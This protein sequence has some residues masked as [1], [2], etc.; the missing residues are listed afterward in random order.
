MWAPIF[1]SLLFQGFGFP[2]FLIPF[3]L[4]VFAF[5]FIFRWEWKYL[6]LKWGGWFVILIATSSLVGLW[7]KPLLVYPKDLLAGGF[8]GEI[9]SR[10]LVRYFNRPG[11]TILLLLILMI[12]FVLGTGI[13]FISLVRRLGN[14]ASRIDEKIGTMRMVRKEQA[15]RAK[16][17]IKSEK[18]EEGKESKEVVPPVVVSKRPLLPKPKEAM[19]QESFEFMEDSKVFQLPPI[20]SAG[21]RCG[22]EA[23]D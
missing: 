17:L 2:S 5:S 10:N 23:E 15:K 11:A 20:T 22:E 13:S 12:A 9:F 16:K 3:L 18:D 8:I 4:G 19:K 6:P 1:P 14:A 7:L 21:G